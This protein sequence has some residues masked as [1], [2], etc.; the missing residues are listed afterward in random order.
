MDQAYHTTWKLAKL[1]DPAAQPCKEL[2]GM[3]LV[4]DPPLDKDDKPAGGVGQM[5]LGP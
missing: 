2:A 3:K 4:C 1:S 5:C